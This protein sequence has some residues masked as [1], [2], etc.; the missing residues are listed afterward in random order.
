[1]AE[2]RANLWKHHPVDRHPHDRPDELYQRTGILAGSLVSRARGVSGTGRHAEC[3][4]D[5]FSSGQR[6]H[7]HVANGLPAAGSRM[8]TSLP[9]QGSVFTDFLLSTYAG[10]KPSLT[11]EEIV[12]ANQWTL[13]AEEA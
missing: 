5:G 8:L 13:A 1:M 10:A 4:C 12:R 9:R 6:R 2:A 7:R 3:D 11:W